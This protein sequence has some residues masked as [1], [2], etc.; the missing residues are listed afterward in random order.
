MRQQATQNGGIQRIGVS[1]V[2]GGTFLAARG[3]F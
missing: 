2:P 1:F 3:S